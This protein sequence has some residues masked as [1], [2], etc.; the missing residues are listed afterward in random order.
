MDINSNEGRELTK[1]PFRWDQ[2]LFSVVLRLPGIGDNIPNGNGGVPESNYQ[3]GESSISAMCDA[4]GGKCY[5]VLNQKSLVQSMESLT[6]K[7]H[8]GVVL[9]FQKTG[10]ND[11]VNGHQEP[12]PMEIDGECTFKLHG[13]ACKVCSQ[14][15]CFVTKNRLVTTLWSAIKW[16]QMGVVL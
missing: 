11:I 2:R 6:Q 4:T 1:E 10:G 14:T 9:N 8:P 13:H 15:E 3:L 12:V 5:V 7:L 16:V